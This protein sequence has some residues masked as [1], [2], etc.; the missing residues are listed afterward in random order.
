MF[1]HG[2]K[3]QKNEFLEEIGLLKDDVLQVIN[4]QS[5]SQSEFESFLNPLKDFQKKNKNLMNEIIK[6]IETRDPKQLMEEILS[7]NDFEKILMDKDQ[8]VINSP[9]LFI[10]MP[11]V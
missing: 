2:K 1:Y 11:L 8:L 9:L 7:N 6:E 10:P 5:H 4:N 3:L